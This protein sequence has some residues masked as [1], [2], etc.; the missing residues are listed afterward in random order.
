MG[1]HIQLIDKRLN[2]NNMKIKA[3]KINNL[4]EKCQKSLLT[5]ANPY[6]RVESLSFFFGIKGL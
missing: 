5:E 1:L 6:Q 3:S 4:E 2:H